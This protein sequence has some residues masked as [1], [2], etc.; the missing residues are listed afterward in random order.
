MC[1]LYN[2]STHVHLLRRLEEVN[3]GYTQRSRM[4]CRRQNNIGLTHSQLPIARPYC[5]RGTRTVR[6]AFCS[7]WFF[8][9]C[10]YDSS[11]RSWNLLLV[12]HHL[13]QSWIVILPP[14]SDF[15]TQEFIHHLVSPL[16][17]YITSYRLCLPV[18]RSW[19]I[20]MAGKWDFF[21]FP[22][23]LDALFRDILFHVS[24]CVGRWAM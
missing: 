20:T 1:T 9:F 4:F 12:E 7:I 13:S 2:T 11:R 17:G 5:H 24:V 23:I 6:C 15:V 10:E 21:L 14:P 8:C 16:T 18:P 22:A 3:K 19:E